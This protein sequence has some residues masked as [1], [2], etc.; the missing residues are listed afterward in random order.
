MERNIEVKE[1]SE[2]RESGM[3]WFVNRILHS[4][5]WVIIIDYDEKDNMIL[6]P[7]RTKFRGFSEESEAKGYKNFAKY[8]KENSEEIYKDTIE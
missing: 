4:V 1:V 5:G 7:A 6:R 8:L 2:F 3:L